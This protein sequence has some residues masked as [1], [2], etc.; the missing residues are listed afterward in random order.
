MDIQRSK[1]DIICKYPEALREALPPRRALWNTAEVA[2]SVEGGVC[3]Y[4][5]AVQS[6]SP[7]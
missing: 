1:I 2:D 3:M 7:W 4:R 5:C 6:Q